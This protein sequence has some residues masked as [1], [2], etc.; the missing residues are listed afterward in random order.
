MK[1][2]PIEKAISAI[3]ERREVVSNSPDCDKDLI[4]MKLI[5]YD[6]CLN[7]LENLLPVE[8][9]YFKTIINNQ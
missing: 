9:E 3:K 8:K 2:T 7:I 1:N 5:S 4:N 6:V